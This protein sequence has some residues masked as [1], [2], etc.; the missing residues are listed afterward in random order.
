MRLLKNVYD[1]KAATRNNII[2]LCARGYA[3]RR[4]RLDCITLAWFDRLRARHDHPSPVIALI[5]NY[6]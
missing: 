1:I 3:A 4:V 2:V 6:Y 5:N